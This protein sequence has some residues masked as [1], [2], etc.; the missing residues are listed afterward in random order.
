MKEIT[1]TDS[2]LSLAED[3]RECKDH[4]TFDECVTKRYIDDLK[5][6]CKCIPINIRGNEEVM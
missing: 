5:E 6:H 2:F 4:E 1:V 3:V